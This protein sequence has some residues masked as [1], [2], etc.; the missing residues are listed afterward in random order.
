[1]ALLAG[2]GEDGPAELEVGRLAGLRGEQRPVAGDRL[3]A[4]GRRLAD[5]PPD[6]ADLRVDLRVLVVAELPDDVG[7]RSRDGDPARRRRPRAGPGRTRPA[8]PACSGRRGA[9]RGSGSGRRSRIGLGRLRVVVRG[10]AADRR[11]RGAPAR[12]AGRAGSA[13]KS[14]SWAF[15]SA[16]KASRRRPRSCLRSIRT[17][18]SDVSAVGSPNVS[19]RAVACERSS[20]VAAL[21][22]RRRRPRARPRASRPAAAP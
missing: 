17:D 7:R 3:G 4:V 14:G 8:R 12:R 6:L 22:Q 5:G 15:S 11:P 9:R 13:G 10:Q 1:M 21:A 16:V 19:A 20:V 2:P 18:R